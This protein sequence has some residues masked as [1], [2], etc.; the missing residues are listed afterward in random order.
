MALAV[1]ITP[2]DI[3]AGFTKATALANRGI[4]L[5]HLDQHEEAAKNFAEAM[6]IEPDN[7]DIYYN[8]CIAHYQAQ[9]FDQAFGSIERAIHLRDDHGPS[10]LLRAEVYEMMGKKLFL[11]AP[12]FFFSI[13]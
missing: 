8:K 9:E 7:P 1:T 6:T 2:D 11:F 13:S 3:K 12:Q 4:I 10:Y 5:S